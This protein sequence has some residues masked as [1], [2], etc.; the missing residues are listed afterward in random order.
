[1]T[2]TPISSYDYALPEN[3]IAQMPTSPR[4]DAR[5]MI[6]DRK[7]QSIKHEYI[8]D[9]PAHI[10]K[11]DVIVVNNSKVF[12]ARLHGEIDGVNKLVEIFLIRPH[13]E[14]TWI[15]IGKPG[16]KLALNTHVIFPENIIGTIVEKH[17]N[18]TM[19]ISF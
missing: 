6:V 15:A 9:L 7:N 8:K 3:L 12:K 14:Y 19:L 4:E 11:N 16:K 10:N 2:S 17:D 5:L 1:M 18:G 13:D